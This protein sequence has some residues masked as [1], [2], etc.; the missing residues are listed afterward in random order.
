MRQISTGQ[1][2]AFLLLFIL[3]LVLGLG[4]S[5][6][7]FG[8]LPLGDFR[9]IALTCAALFCVYIY[10]FAV[11]RLFLSILPLRE[12]DIAEGSQEEFVAQVNILFYLIL[13]NSLIRTHFLPVP[14]LRLVYLALGARLGHNT[15]SAGAILD[16]PLTYIGNNC[17]IG[18]DAVLFSHAIESGRLSLSAIHIGDNVTIGATAVVMSGVTIGDGAIVS[19]G[20]VVTKGSRIGNGEVWGGVP[21]KLLKPAKGS[22][23]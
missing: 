4:T 14:L 13:F 11:Y 22:E 15:Y 19:A 9:G 2:L 5:W 12:G 17:I 1:I 10:A 7:V 21:A 18:H 3:I 16:P 23:V 20:A 8:S 6:L